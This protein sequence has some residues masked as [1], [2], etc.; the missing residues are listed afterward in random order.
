MLPTRQSLGTKRFDVIRQTQKVTANTT[1]VADSLGCPAEVVFSDILLVFIVVPS[2]LATAL[3]A[4][5]RRKDN[6][7]CPLIHAPI[8]I[9]RKSSTFAVRKIY[10]Q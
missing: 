4:V 6:D 9:R 7:F 1:K 2:T 10:T 3:V 5:T 8:Q